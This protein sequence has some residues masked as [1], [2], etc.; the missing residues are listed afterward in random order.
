[1]WQDVVIGSEYGATMMRSRNPTRAVPIDGRLH[2]RQVRLL[3]LLGALGG[4]VRN[5]D[6]QKLLFL[7][8]QELSTAG[9]EIPTSAL[10]EFVPYRYGAFSFTSY[11][12]RRRLVE[13]GLLMESETHWVLTEY[14]KHIVRG[15][16]TGSVRRFVD[17]HTG[18]RGDKLIAETY[19]RHPY[20]AV[21]STIAER[22]LEGDDLAL[23]QVKS[24]GP[25]RNGGLLFTIG[26][27]GRSLEQYLNILLKAS[28]TVLCDVRRNAMS[29]KYG[30]AKKTLATACSGIGLRYE[31]LPKLGIESRQRQNLK[32]QDDFKALFGVYERDLLPMQSDAIR[33]ILT[34]LRSG[35]SIA[36]TCYEREAV[37]CHRHCIA[38]KLERILSDESIELNSSGKRHQVTH[39]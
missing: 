19:R 5:L 14:G 6:F 37:Q 7:F 17:R 32:T 39:L 33:Q 21:R 22:V 29:R 24:A 36:L 30:F 11:A 13:R 28:V 9:R 1:M 35:E 8:C 18:L 12:D 16:E 20:F 25:K 3:G 27:Q 31:H 15:Y 34:W 2:D 38:S 26:Y 10:Y 4:R 23:R